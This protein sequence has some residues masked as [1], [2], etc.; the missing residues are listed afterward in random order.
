MLFRDIQKFRSD[1]IG[2]GSEGEEERRR[3]HG[4]AAGGGAGKAGAPRGTAAEQCHGTLRW[5]VGSMEKEEEGPASWAAISPNALSAPHEPC[6]THPKAKQTAVSLHRPQGG[7]AQGLR[8]RER[9]RVRGE[10]YARRGQAMAPKRRKGDRRI[11]AAIDHFAPMGYTARQ[12]RTAVNALLKEYLG[13]AAWRFLEDDSY[14]VVQ[15]RLLEMEEEEKKLLEQETQEEE[16]PELEQEQPQQHEPALDEVPPQSNSLM[17]EGHSG[18]SAGIES[19]DEELED[20]MIV[21]PLAV[22]AVAPLTEA[23]AVVPFAEATV[24]GDRRPP[25]YGWLSESEDEEQQTCE[26]RE[27]HLP[28]PG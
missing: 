10:Y 23:K 5:R 26:Q 25:C 2:R 19:S 18:E 22:E 27:V 14:L 21:E 9:E 20:P 28:S 11:D 3:V 7:K 13:A 12:V 6:A 1:S 17:L 4:A 15:E 16:E 24:T 8:E